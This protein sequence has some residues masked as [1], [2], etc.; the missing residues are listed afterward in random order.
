MKQD[1]VLELASAGAFLGSHRDYLLPLSHELNELIQS[2][3]VGNSQINGL[4][5]L[6]DAA[7]ALVF[8]TLC[9]KKAHKLSRYCRDKPLDELTALELVMKLE[10]K[11]WANEIKAPGARVPVYKSQRCKKIWCRP[12]AKPVSRFYLQ[13]CLSVDSLL[14]QGLPGLVHLQPEGYYRAIMYCLQYDPCKLKNIVAHKNASFYRAIMGEPEPNESKS[15]AEL[16][17]D[18]EPSIFEQLEMLEEGQQDENNDGENQSNDETHDGVAKKDLIYR[19]LYIRQ[20]DLH[21][22]GFSDGCEACLSIQSGISRSGIQHSEECRNRIMQA[23]ETTAEG[24]ERL[25]ALVERENLF[26]A[27]VLEI[28]EQQTA[29][30]ARRQRAL[31]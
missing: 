6:T 17:F 25:E 21:Q 16:E 29:L 22:H 14:E 13:S 2:G 23:L 4:V 15:S 9:L 19:R 27:R 28:Q 20:Q 11:G 3:F 12:A 24:K 5:H 1:I 7:R 30:P 18:N 8:P 10:Q 26:I 31:L